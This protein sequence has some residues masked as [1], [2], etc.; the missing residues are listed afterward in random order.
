ML[1]RKKLKIIKYI[2]EKRIKKI[3]KFKNIKIYITK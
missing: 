3:L 1:F 2:I